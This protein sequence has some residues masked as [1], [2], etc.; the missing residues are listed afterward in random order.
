MA[1]GN[2]T[3]ITLVEGLVNQVS[4]LTTFLQAL[5]GVILVYIIFNVINAVINRK[6]KKQL[7][8]INNN[9]EDIKKILKGKKK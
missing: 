7:E 5:G 3:D 8:L 2:F 1:I 9:L 6:K 4:S